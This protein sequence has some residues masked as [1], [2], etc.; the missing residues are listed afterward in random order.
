MQ[1]EIAIIG[2]GKM[3]GGLAHNL[4]DSGWRVVGYNR[5]ASVTKEFENEG[6]V[7]AY[8]FAEVV[9]KLKN[10]QKL[11]WVMVPS[12]KPVQETLLG[13]DGI[14]K[15]LSKGD[16]LI[17]GGNSFYKETLE[18]A[19]QIEDMGIN[20]LD[21]G[22]SGGPG[23]ARNGACMMAG[24]NQEIFDQIEELFS[25]SCVEK[26]YG[27]MGK[28]GAGHFVKMVHNGIEYG[29]MQAIA[30]GFDVMH[31]TDEFE[32]DLVKV[33]QVYNHGSVITS[34][35]V[36]WM[37]EGYET[38]GE[39]LAEI[40]GKAKHSGEGE[41]TVKTAEQMGINVRV[42]KDSLQAREDSQENPNYQAQVI[43]T[44]RNMFGGHAA[45]KK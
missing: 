33:S 44:L 31:K 24:G 28:H 8:S 21:V 37:Q 3:G 27:L 19:K 35:L 18:R 30:E 11:V 29:M 16:I 22:V 14:T 10:E 17:D 5:T 9:E 43:M 41:W 1:K 12:G 32:L 6:L 34:S 40:T 4:M 25:D 26:G 39:D 2:L 15:Y 45:E 38:Y 7:G 13:E 23:G 36:G 42:I 20:F